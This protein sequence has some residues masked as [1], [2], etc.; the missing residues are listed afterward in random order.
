M[1]SNLVDQNGPAPRITLPQLPSELPHGLLRPPESVRQMLAQE[2]AKHPPESFSPNTEERMLN[3]WTLQH[4]FDDC[5]YEVLYRPT[6]NGP[7]IMAVGFEE[8]VAFRKALPL[9][10]QLQFNTW[11]PY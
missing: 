9:E 2:K 6:P 1:A 3:D 7:A 5:G 10:E 8:M 11:L 4:F